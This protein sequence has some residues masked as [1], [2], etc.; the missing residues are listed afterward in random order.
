MKN[1]K[2]YIPKKDDEAV[3]KSISLDDV[4]IRLRTIIRMTTLLS[5]FYLATL[6]GLVI[7]T[8][9][10]QKSVDQQGRQIREQAVQIERI[11]NTLLKATG[12]DATLVQQSIL[13]KILFGQCK[14][15]FVTHKE[16]FLAAGDKT[17]EE[18]ANRIYL[19]NPILPTSDIV[20]SH[21]NNNK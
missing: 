7:A 13:Y 17:V 1:F 12:A 5:F 4:G 19:S 10:Q 21:E 14:N 18:C 9:S 3:V 15:Q 2:V 16:E 6:S 11:D 8:S 20:L